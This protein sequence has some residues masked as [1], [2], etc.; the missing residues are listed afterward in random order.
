MT[1]TTTDLTRA[2]LEAFWDGWLAVNREAER[3]GDWRVLAEEYAEDA[4]YGW[5][6]SVDEHF[7]AVGRDQIRDWAI[8][9]EMD[10]FDGWHYDYVATVM[11][12]KNGMVVGFWKQRSGIVDDATGKEYEILGIGGSWFGIER[13]TGGADDGQLKIA[14]QRDWF[15]MPSTA[16]TF[17]EILKSGKAP[18]TL[19]A[20]MKVSGHGV[21]GH[22]H[23]ADIPSPV[24]PPPVEAGLHVRPGPTA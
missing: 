22:Y 10:G 13:Q 21:P 23:L 6:Y 5:M 11:D 15:D 2:E 4:S 14:W 24:W 20:R 7:M 8:G 18:D 19:L 9:I 16:H 1:G 17:M 3:Q 12:E